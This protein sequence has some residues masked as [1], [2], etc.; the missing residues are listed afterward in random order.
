VQTPIGILDKIIFRDIYR[1]E[2]GVVVINGQ[3][4]IATIVHP[5]VSKMM[6]KNRYTQIVKEPFI[7]R[8]YLHRCLSTVNESNVGREFEKYAQRYDLYAVF[9][10]KRKRLYVV[11]RPSVRYN[12]TRIGTRVFFGY[13]AVISIEDIRELRV[14]LTCTL[15]DGR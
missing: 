15:H 4:V 2:I 13:D 8:R 1:S 7:L 14:S 12:E 5:S 3:L 9:R 10:N 6:R 11:L